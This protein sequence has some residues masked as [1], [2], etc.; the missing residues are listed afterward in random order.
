VG[1]REGAAALQ[2][3]KNFARCFLVVEPMKC[4]CATD[5]AGSTIRQRDRFRA[6]DQ[7]LDV[8]RRSA[9]ENADGHFL[10]RLD[11]QNALAGGC[12]QRQLPVVGQRLVDAVADPVAAEQQQQREAGKDERVV[13][14]CDR[15]DAVHRRLDI[16][17][18]LSQPPRPLSPTARDLHPLMNA[19]CT[20]Q[21][22][23]TRSPAKPAPSSAIAAFM[24]ITV[25]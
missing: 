21:D 18:H 25:A 9:D 16:E 19:C 14:A 6:A 2:H 13:L 8:R 24:S 1:Q 7:H 15:G 3:A 11:R 5:E 12:E 20:Q 4:R 10:D 17:A 22:C 23:P